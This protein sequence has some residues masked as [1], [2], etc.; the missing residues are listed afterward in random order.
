M[1][2]FENICKDGPAEIDMIE[3]IS[4]CVTSMIMKC[5]FGEDMSSDEPVDF[6]VN[7]LNRP[8][9]VS[10]VLRTCF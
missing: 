8:K 4:V 3:E 6:F 1:N 9:N 7:G 2:H 5:I 10:F